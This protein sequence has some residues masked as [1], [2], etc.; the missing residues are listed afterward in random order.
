M[1]PKKKDA[2]PEAKATADAAATDAKT[3]AT[4]VDA[5]AKD[6]KKPAEP[7]KKEAEKL[8][9]KKEAEKPVVKKEAAK[10]GWGTRD[11]AAPSSLMLTKPETIVVSPHQVAVSSFPVAA[12]VAFGC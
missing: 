7:K 4:P 8:V 11:V 10:W 3:Q 9:V 6:V 5:K 1:Q 12:C 2:A